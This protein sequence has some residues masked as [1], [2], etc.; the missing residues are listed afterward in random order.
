MGQVAQADHERDDDQSGELPDPE[1]P[2]LRDP[3]HEQ[4]PGRGEP[5]VGGG[6]ADHEREPEAQLGDGLQLGEDL[7][8]V[9]EE[10]H[11]AV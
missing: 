1:D 7:A 11:H 6:E 10:P 5:H 2:Q 3:Q 8:V 9:G 4:E